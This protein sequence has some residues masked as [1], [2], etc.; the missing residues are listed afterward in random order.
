MGLS[1]EEAHCALRFSLGRG[2][3]EEEIERTLALM[4]EMIR[5]TAAAVRFVPCR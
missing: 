1:P 5:D 3:T 4:E 2:N